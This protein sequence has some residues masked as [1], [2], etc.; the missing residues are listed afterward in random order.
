MLARAEQLV[1]QQGRKLLIKQGGIQLAH[2]HVKSAAHR[3]THTQRKQLRTRK[4]AARGRGRRR[5]SG[6]PPQQWLSAPTQAP[7]A[8]SPTDRELRSARIPPQQ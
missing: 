3:D 1:T 7:H 6:A 4:A 5:P 2:L 8:Q